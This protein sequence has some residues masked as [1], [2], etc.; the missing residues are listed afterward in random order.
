MSA[1]QPILRGLTGVSSFLVI[2]VGA[3]LA[4]VLVPWLFSPGTI[5]F[6]MACA[7]IVVAAAVLSRLN[8]PSWYP[9]ALG[10]SYF[11]GVFGFRALILH[12]SPEFYRLT[13]PTN[14]E[15]GGVALIVGTLSWLFATAAVVGWHTSAPARRTILNRIA[16]GESIAAQTQKAIAVGLISG[17]V[18]T[19]MILATVGGIGPALTQTKDLRFLLSG[20]YVFAAL[21]WL[22]SVSALVVL[23]LPLAG[24]H[25]GRRSRTVAWLLLIGAA[26]TNLVIG[27]RGTAV[28]FLLAGAALALFEYFPNNGRLTP[29]VRWVLVLS[30]VVGLFGLVAF[31]ILRNASNPFR[32]VTIESQLSFSALRDLVSAGRRVRQFDEYDG[33][34]F[35]V[36][37]TN[38]DLPR[39]W[40]IL[41]EE[42]LFP[43]QLLP[44]ALGIDKS[45]SYGLDIREL[46]LGQRRALTGIPA[47]LAGEGYLLAGPIGVAI[48]GSLFG[49]VA[50]LS[51]DI[52]V[53]IPARLTP[54]VIASLFIGHVPMVVSRSLTFV[55]GRL[56]LLSIMASGLVWLATQPA[57]TFSDP[58]ESLN[59][60]SKS[61]RFIDP[62]DRVE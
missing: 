17:L 13:E 60:R 44:T 41:R 31:G 58:R 19:V 39:G 57:R 4:S 21:T 55:L 25:I 5:A 2:A 53:R 34:L 23:G 14:D 51:V 37:A 49:M 33:M 36:A 24:V 35:A 22:S 61:A 30:I 48:L 50:A 12:T 8:T 56:L 45:R 26:A 42:I 11:A 7:W 47:T 46:G 6:A 43:T 62:R 40:E 16:S 54:V 52:L 27:S 18:G 15:L 38:E 29:R 20:S 3:G 59:A 9:V 32:G 10:T 28:P 1:V